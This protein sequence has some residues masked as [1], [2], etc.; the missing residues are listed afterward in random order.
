MKSYKLNQFC[1]IKDHTNRGMTRRNGNNKP[2]RAK[3]VVKKGDWLQQ[4]RL[5][6][7]LWRHNQND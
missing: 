6:R 1:L 3:V 4:L 7:N 5:Q 2:K